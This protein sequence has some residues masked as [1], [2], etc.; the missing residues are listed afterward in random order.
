MYYA[1]GVAAYYVVMNYAVV[2][3]HAFAYNDV[4]YRIF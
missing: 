1:G 3:Q 2:W 4:F